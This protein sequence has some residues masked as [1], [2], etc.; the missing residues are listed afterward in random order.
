MD[1]V[2]RTTVVPAGAW[3]LP[4][5]PEGPNPWNEYERKQIAWEK[6]KLKRREGEK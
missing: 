6:R 4:S 5:G 3:A 2:N 1:L